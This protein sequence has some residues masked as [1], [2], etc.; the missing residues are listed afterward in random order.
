MTRIRMK[1][2]RGSLSVKKMKWPNVISSNFKRTSTKTQKY[3]KRY[4]KYLNLNR[5]KKTV[6]KI[7]SEIIYRFRYSFKL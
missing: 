1:I 5:H 7:R 2:L 4:S 6:L 3:H